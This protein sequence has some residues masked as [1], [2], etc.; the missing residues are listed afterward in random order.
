MHACLQRCAL[1]VCSLVAAC[2]ATK[3]DLTLDDYV[4]QGMARTH[5]Q[6]LAVAVI[7]D[8]NNTRPGKALRATSAG[9][10]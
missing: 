4:A 5:A 9:A 6:G 8:G 2:A 1:F 3:R 10:S 7:D